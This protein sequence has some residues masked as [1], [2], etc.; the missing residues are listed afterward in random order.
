MARPGKEGALPTNPRLGDYPALTARRT[1]IGSSRLAFVLTAST[2]QKY[3]HGQ[4]RIVYV[5]TT[6]DGARG[7]AQGIAKHA[8]AILGL[9][10]VRSFE[11]RIVTCH[12]RQ[13]VK[14][15]LKL[16]KA[17]LMAFRREF[18]AVPLCN[19]KGRKAKPGDEASYFRRDRVEAII[20][21]LS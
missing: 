3:P 7:L 20:R 19:S 10:G 9:H 8:D 1:A 17:L 14:T 18:G 2:P 21:E 5:G 11:A 16:E 4:S 13:N 6:P 12:S 15:W